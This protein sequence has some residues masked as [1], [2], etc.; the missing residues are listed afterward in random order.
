MNFLETPQ[1]LARNIILLKLFD[2]FRGMSFYLPIL[3]IYFEHH[4]DVSLTEFF[5]TEVCFALTLVFFEVPSGY[6]SDVW[7]RKNVMLLGALVGTVSYLILFLGYGFYQ[8]V[9]A[10]VLMA[11]AL[12]LVS[13]TNSSLMYD[14]LLDLKAEKEYKM[15]AGQMNAYNFAGTGVATIAGGWLYNMYPDMPVLITVFFVFL[16]VGCAALMVEPHRVKVEK[17]HAILQDIA[18]TVKYCLHGHKEIF[19]IILVTCFVLA[20]TK[21]GFL[22]HQPLWVAEGVDPAFMGILMAAMQVVNFLLS[23]YAHQIEDKIGLKNT[24]I[25]MVL[26][27]AVIYGLAGA[28]GGVIALFLVT[29]PGFAFCVGRVAAEHALH[30]RVGS[31]RRATVLSVANLMPHFIFMITA[32]F[33][34]LL[35]ET[36]GIYAILILV[37]LVILTLGLPSLFYLR[38]HKVV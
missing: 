2:F 23:Y 31:G 15:H 33:V 37:A 6:L 28:F 18:I 11:I 22:L 13:G 29:I 24:F 17:K 32:P 3:V 16:G 8:M 30:E 5:I 7:K 4:K 9:F 38:R 25:L 27:P 34:G 10:Q 19:A 14:T 26:W 1:H 35:T 21:I 12:S 20:M 36:Y